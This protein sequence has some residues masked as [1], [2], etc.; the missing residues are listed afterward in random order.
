MLPKTTVNFEK[1]QHFIL[2]VM[3]LK[4]KAYIKEQIQK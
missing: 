2:Y 1:S 3:L 4:R